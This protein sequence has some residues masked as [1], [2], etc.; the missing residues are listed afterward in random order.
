MIPRQS[1]GKSF[2][3]TVEFPENF[4][5]RSITYQT[6]PRGKATTSAT[7][8]PAP[9]ADTFVGTGFNILPPFGQLEVSQDGKQ[10]AKVCDLQPIYRAHENWQQKTISFPAVEGKF[11]RLNLHDWWLPDAAYQDLY[12]GN[13]EINGA[14]KI[15]QWEEKAGLFSEYIDDEKTP[16]YGKNETIDPKKIVD[17]SDKMDEN[18]IL[19][20][21]VPKGRWVILRFMQ[22]PTGGKIKHGRNNL[23]G[24]ECDKMSVQAAEIQFAHYFKQILDTLQKENLP[25]SGMIMDSHEAG[26]QNWTDDFLTEFERRRG[27]S[28]LR[29][30]P[31]M[32]GY[33]VDDTEKT[34]GV[35]YDV[36]RTI[37]DLISDR[38][39]GTFQKLST[40]NG[41]KFT[42]QATGN[43][44][45]I[46]ADPIQAKSKVEIPQGEFWI[47]HPDGNYDIKESSSAA[48]L[49]DKH[50]VSAEAYTGALYEHTLADL[51]H[52][53][54]GAYCFGINE[55]AVCASAYQPWDSTRLPGNMARGLEWI[56]NRNNTWWSYSREFWNYQ[57]RC[58]YVLRRGMPVVDLCLYLGDNAPVKILAY[59]LPEIPAGY[60]FDAAT[61]DA[62][63]TRMSAK[64][65]KIVLP[66]G[67]SY[68]MLVLP[69][70][71]E[72]SFA[73]LE[74]IAELVN[75]GAR[76]WGNRPVGSPSFKDNDRKKEY[77]KIVAQLWGETTGRDTPVV[78]GKG[79]VYQEMSL[80]QAL[81]AEKMAPDLYM[82]TNGN[83]SLQISYYN[84]GIPGL[85]RDDSL[86]SLYFV[87]RKLS[88]ADMYFLNNHKKTA[89][90]GNF[91][92]RSKYGNVQ[93]W[94]AVTGKRYAVP[95]VRK[96]EN[97]VTVN[98]NFSP[99]ESFFIVCTDTPSEA[100]HTIPPQEW[101]AI[102]EINDDWNVYFSENFGGQGWVHFP[103]LTDWTQ[104]DHNAIRYYSGTAI[105]K[106][107]IAGTQWIAPAQKKFIELE[108]NNCVSDVY[109]NGIKA[110]TV[111]C[112]PYRLEITGLLRE[113][114]NTL[115]IHCCN[116]WQNRLI[117]DSALPENQRIT[118]T[119]YSVAKPGDKL[120]AAG[121]TGVTLKKQ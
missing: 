55:F 87:H 31:A 57:S 6:K 44:L 25:I 47:I 21:D 22:V 1:A 119:N 23:M 69:R 28:L 59:R 82:E 35:L 70:S 105:Y 33:V 32:W 3:V 90:S 114:K 11:F 16:R 97:A 49:Y 64:D 20:W 10:Y 68:S 37:A 34:A 66:N 115:E 24:L 12:V 4:T 61:Q 39:Y 95:V 116:T 17:L 75:N 51:K 92:F 103:K 29:H 46:V 41:V 99:Q 112:S 118:Y 76:V 81:E 45:C 15:D 84:Q 8:V 2:F 58:A 13:V 54:D 83:P 100:L 120:Q 56:A 52:I 48:H 93:L 121:L 111:W 94:D 67:I 117:G 38:Y 9:S 53:A 62:L 101:S 108:M 19:R 63:L 106:K 26:A 98:L 110:G 91:T 42:A 73:A 107:E 96:T 109:I 86:N 5:A 40:G 60:D 79:R 88:D 43:A 85:F 14:A 89:L 7:N 27:Y 113:G 30:L 65:G 74:K 18:G 50:I 71:G 104:N 36:R 80:K 72:I 102:E 78:F 77:E